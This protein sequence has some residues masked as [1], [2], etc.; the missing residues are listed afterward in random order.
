[1]GKAISCRCPVEE[2]QD[3]VLPLVIGMMCLRP[4]H[5]LRWLGLESGCAPGGPVVAA[6]GLL[7][8]GGGAG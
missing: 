1:M 5:Q 3:D 8:G 7:P 6:G 4:I 2:A